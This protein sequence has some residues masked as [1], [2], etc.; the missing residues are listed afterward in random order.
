MDKTI[1]FM[2]WKNCVCLFKI[3]LDQNQTNYHKLNM[4]KDIFKKQYFWKLEELSGMIF[5][6][7][8][9]SKN[10]FPCKIKLSIQKIPEKKNHKK[11]DIFEY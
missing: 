1:K 9:Y 5:S 4:F 3:N 8:L 6:P 2:C 10:H 11:L 7:K